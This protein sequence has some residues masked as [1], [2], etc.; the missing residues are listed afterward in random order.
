MKDYLATARSLDRNIG[1]VLDYLDKN[2]LNENT[3]VIY[4]SG[5]GILYR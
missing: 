4:A 1:R 2:G 3:I 5:P